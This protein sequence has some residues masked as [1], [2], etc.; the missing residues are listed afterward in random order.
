MGCTGSCSDNCSS[1]CD[2][3]C[4]TSCDTGCKEGC[5][6]QC[7][8][9]CGTGCRGSGCDYGCTDDC[10]RGCSSG[11][12]SGCTTACRNSCADSCKSGCKSS[13]TG[14][15]NTACGGTNRSLDIINLGN[16]IKSG[17]LSNYNDF[18]NLKNEMRNEIIRRGITAPSNYTTTVDKSIPAHAVSISA[19]LAQN[20][21]DTVNAGFT[22]G[23]KSTQ[24]TT[25]PYK[26]IKS[27]D[28][29]RASDYSQVIKYITDLMSTVVPKP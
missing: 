21:F 19:K 25:N 17:N 8:T 26:Q 2:N 4:Y 7:T 13:C 24:V 11:C 5:A 6:Y 16:N 3:T 29:V 20:V 10:G 27:G 14:D 23:I 12:D 28:V 9:Q 1:G 18:I 22:N 15:C